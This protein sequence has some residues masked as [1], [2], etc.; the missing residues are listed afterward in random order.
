MSQVEG[1]VGRSGRERPRGRAGLVSVAVLPFALAFLGELVVYAVLR[2]RLPGR[3]ASHFGADGAADGYVG[4]GAYLVVGSAL[5]VGLG[6]VAVFMVLKSGFGTYRRGL[7]GLLAGCWAAAAFLGWPMAASLV[8]NR[9]LAD[10]ASARFPLWQ[11]AVAVGVAAVAAGVGALLGLALARRMAL[12]DVPAGGAARD[13][14]AVRLGLGDA[15]VAGWV[16]RTGSAWLGGLGAAMAGAGVALAWMQGEW[17]GSLVLVAA[18]LLVAAFARPCVTVDRRGLTV[19]PSALAWP[20]IRLPLDR[21]ER[22]DSESI[23]AMADYGGWGYRVRPGR[24]G[25]IVRSGEALVVRRTS[26][27]LFAVTVEDSATAAALLNT[28][29]ERRTAER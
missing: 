15:E 11:L 4:R 23:N 26:G 8:A 17:T 19:S 7:A 28:L 5:F 18:G 29:V 27:K 10:G 14:D 24:S 3:I 13:A 22:A 6:A 1:S 12:S 16:R 25:V 2:D 9:D 20:R 21:I